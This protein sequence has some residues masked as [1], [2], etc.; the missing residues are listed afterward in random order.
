VLA[1]LVSCAEDPPA[2][3]PSGPRPGHTLFDQLE[4]VRVESHSASNLPRL[5][6]D[7]LRGMVEQP[8]RDLPASAFAPFPLGQLDRGQ[9]RDV[10]ALALQF[11]KALGDDAGGQCWRA[12]PE[13]RLD[14][15]A[16]RVTLRHEGREVSGVVRDDTSAAGG[17]LVW[18]DDQ[19][20]QLF[21]WDAVRGYLLAFGPTPPGDV[22]YA[23]DLGARSP[24]ASAEW[25]LVSGA[26]APADAR[27]LAGTFTLEPTTRPCLLAPAPTD[28]SLTLPELPG[29]RLQVVVGVLDV[30]SALRG[31]KQ[32]DG[33]TFSVEVVQAGEPRSLWSRHVRAEEGFVEADVAMTDVGPG[34]LELRLLT[35]PG[36]DG[37]SHYDHGLWSG[38]TFRDD[39]ARPP[40][41]PHLVL[42]DVDTLRADRLGCYGYERETS[43]RIDAWARREAEV[44]TDAMAVANWTLP[45]TL[46]I[47][48]GLS[49]PEHGVH[50]VTRRLSETVPTLAERL[51]AA[52]YETLARTDG[53]YVSEPY[54]FAR[55][56]DSFR[57]YQ[58]PWRAHHAAGWSEELQGLAARGSER[59]VFLFLQTY[60]VHTPLGNDHTFDDPEA[61]YDGTWSDTQISHNTLMDHL[62]Q[63]GMPPDAWDRRWIS[64]QYDAAVKRMDDVVGA[65]L[66]G[67]PGVFGDEP[68]LVLITSDHG[69]ELFD[70]GGFGHSRSLY[71]EL[72]H[73]PLIVRH[74]DGLRVGENALPA[75]GL[76]V[77]PTLLDSA[78]LPVPPELSGLS[79]REPP[80]PS[81]VRTAAHGS[82]GHAYVVDGWKLVQGV[83]LPGEQGEQAEQAGSR[84]RLFELRADPGE[85][86]D[87]AQ[88][89]ADRTAG[90][91]KALARHLAE[92]TPILGEGGTDQA[93]IDPALA[94]QL[95][96][97]GYLGDQD[98]G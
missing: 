59:P 7:R 8:V 86:H 23:F 82:D 12:R 71:A 61:P 40:A 92:V 5:L 50:E 76:D 48:T 19:A 70:R 49:V 13:L 52:G 16:G 73:V 11:R 60:Q 4:D 53:G 67:L 20:P 15:G 68:Y 78:G 10:N 64:D 87:L 22:S 80:R 97:L 45:S 96:E 47:L 54:G 58:R 90:M 1:G 94:E 84:S 91:A 17:A 2:P 42:I 24:L 44:F 56:F 27:A 25:R 88:T 30:R 95:R 98:D 46:S 31:R 41:R 28:L 72:I 75:S 14:S 38:L 9:L 63:G 89:Q 51:R 66:E 39:E 36:P 35:R 55:G 18:F 74:P 29:R 37:S 85:Q 6:R 93:P 65:F 79:L 21:W 32:G 43:P 83:T 81:R 26:E 33:V 34:P 77:V 62:A 57:A 69:E 3:A